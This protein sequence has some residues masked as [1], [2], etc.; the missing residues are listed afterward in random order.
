ML[1]NTLHTLFA[2]FTSLFSYNKITRVLTNIA[3]KSINY[4]TAH[5]TGND[6]K[7][8]ALTAIF[9]DLDNVLGN[10]ANP[11]TKQAVIDNID[12]FFIHMAKQYDGAVELNV[13]GNLWH[14]KLEEIS[15]TLE[16]IVVS[17]IDTPVVNRYN[18]TTT[19]TKMVVDMMMSAKR[20]TKCVL[21]SCDVDFEHPAAF[22]NQINV[23]F[24]LIQFGPTSYRLKQL[25]SMITDGFLIIKEAGL[26]FNNSSSEAQT[27]QSAKDVLVNA[28]HSA[29]KPCSLGEAS[30]L[31]AA[32]K[33]DTWQGH[34]SFTQFVRAMNIPNLQISDGMPGF[35]SIATPQPKAEAKQRDTS[36]K[37]AQM[38]VPLLSAEQY[39]LIFK[40]L[41]T[42]TLGNDV[43]SLVEQ[44]RAQ[45]LSEGCDLS[46]N[47]IESVVFKLLPYIHKPTKPSVLANK[48]LKWIF[49]KSK[50]SFSGLLN[51][52]DRARLS[53]VIL[54]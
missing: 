10:I 49:Q 11:Q 37:L 54:A 24:D 23:P 22:F 4:T 47:T 17:Y 43:A 13:Y 14:W 12:L 39:H 27:Q 48:Y 26:W 30:Q 25:V 21:V 7:K 41:S 19:D 32:Y 6:T 5:E 31:L 42:N 3:P 53:E 28:L 51:N 2:Q 16:D 15:F 38:D 35:I 50:V 29:K 1:S 46:P 34:R 20:I 8:A 52:H 45:C 44:T 18:K 33:N 36:E 9:V 40:V